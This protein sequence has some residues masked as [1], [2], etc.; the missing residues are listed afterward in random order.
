MSHERANV[1]V[2]DEQ[3]PGVFLYTHSGGPRLPL[4]VRGA[5]M[6]RQRWNQAPYLARLIFSGMTWGSSQGDAGFGISSILG[7]NN[8]PVIVVDTAKQTVSYISEDDAREKRTDRP[9]ASWSFEEY[10]QAP[11][12][13]IAGEIWGGGINPS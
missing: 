1:L 10:V 12:R 8:Y 2:K 7:D 11:A 6:R 4:L 9:G 3:D 13:A 5:L